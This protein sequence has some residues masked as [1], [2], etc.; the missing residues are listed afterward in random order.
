MD[1]KLRR[2]FR[3]WGA[4]MCS[5]ILLGCINVNVPKKTTVD[6]GG[7]SF[8]RDQFDQ[9]RTDMNAREPKRRN[10]SKKQARA[11]AHQLIRDHGVSLSEYKIKDEKVEG[12]YWF[13]YENKRPRENKNWRNCFAVRVTPSGDISFYKRPAPNPK[14]KK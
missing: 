6:I 2:I 9:P 1:L 8:E 5:I 10:I 3:L 11:M 4:L 12:N 13:I 14:T 7:A